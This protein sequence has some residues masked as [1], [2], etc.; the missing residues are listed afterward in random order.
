MK[1][2]RLI[3]ASFGLISATL[4]AS[5]S[6]TFAW[7]ASG[8]L[9]GVNPIVISFVGEK[10]IY[11]ALP[12]EN[13]EDEIDY[14]TTLKFNDEVDD[15]VYR[16][17]SSM[18]SQEWLDIFAS[19]PV[20]RTGYSQVTHDNVDSYTKGMAITLDEDGYFSKELYLYSKYNVILTLD[21]E[22]TTFLPD[23]KANK[24]TAKSLSDNQI[25]I[26]NITN[27]L[28]NV[29]KSLRMSLLIP[30]EEHE[31]H[32]E[33]KYYIVDPHKEEVTY[34]CGPLDTNDPGVEYYDCYYT[35]TDTY[36]YY[37]GEYNNES[38]LIYDTSLDEDTPLSLSGRVT[39][40]NA[41]HRKGTRVVNIEQSEANGFIRGKE[42]SLT[43]NEADITTDEGKDSGIR[44][45][46][47]AFEKKKVVLSMYL[48]G[49]DKDNI[50]YTEKG[51]FT[52][53]IQFKIG[54]EHF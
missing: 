11:A 10:E 5:I 29:T 38:K 4:I 27:D 32:E 26:E 51:Q 21:A 17:V 24:N 53:N 48:E 45:K 12:P 47:D 7:Y 30:D 46:L 37:F 22:G 39:K 16:P 13:P 54:E 20:F 50:G 9:L 23:E 52:A 28:N 15:K 49:W 34:L 19:K 43:L 2:D 41:K 36:E 42:N 6:M 1:K 14:Q 18:F 8:E 35:E 25:E 40:F 31:N 33:Y 44:I 3:I